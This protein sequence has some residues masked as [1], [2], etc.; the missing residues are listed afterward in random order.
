MSHCGS[1]RFANK[2][3]VQAREVVEREQERAVTQKRETERGHELLAKQEEDY[4]T[5]MDEMRDLQ[6]KIDEKLL[7]AEAL[8]KREADLND[9]EEQL[10][11]RS[12]KVARKEDF[13]AKERKIYREGKTQLALLEKTRKAKLAKLNK[14]LGE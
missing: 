12:K 13:V 7:T 11:E 10:I 3:I 8:D 2:L 4:V 14:M 1:G 9:Q 6:K 5:K